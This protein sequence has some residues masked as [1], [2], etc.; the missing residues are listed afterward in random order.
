MF[1]VMLPIFAISHFR[2]RYVSDNF[3]RAV[4]FEDCSGVM[5]DVADKWK[6]LTDEERV[7]RSKFLYFLIGPHSNLEFSVGMA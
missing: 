2:C 3:P 6:S 1:R 7:V 5:K 4:S